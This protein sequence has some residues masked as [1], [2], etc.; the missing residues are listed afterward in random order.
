MNN[1]ANDTYSLAKYIREH[2]D[3]VYD[4]LTFKECQDPFKKYNRS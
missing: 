1:K 4:Q 2:E 3:I